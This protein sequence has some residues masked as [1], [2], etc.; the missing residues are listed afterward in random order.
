ML[1]GHTL[2]LIMIDNDVDEDEERHSEEEDEEVEPLLH[3]H[4][5]A[6]AS[7]PFSDHD[8]ENSWVGDPGVYCTFTHFPPTC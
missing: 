4:T 1:T 8:G 2:E 5:S 3:R 7:P 6:R